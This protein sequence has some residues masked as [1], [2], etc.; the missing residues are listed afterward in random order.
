MSL[1]GV[2]LGVA[3]LEPT[4][5]YT[6]GMHALGRL[7][8]HVAY[9]GLGSLESE[10]GSG[11]G[12][13]AAAAAAVATATAAAVP[14]APRPRSYEAN[15]AVDEAKAHFT[16]LDMLLPTN[17]AAVPSAGSSSGGARLRVG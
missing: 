4:L 6:Q 14:A 17:L 9:E 15:V 10:G 5:R 8:L 13:G 11:E 2:L 1:Q 3:A 7:C 16:L 12:G